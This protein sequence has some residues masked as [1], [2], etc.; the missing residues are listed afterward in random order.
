MN[1]SDFRKLA[2]SLPDTA[3][4]A[5]MGHPDFRVNGRIFAT[6]GPRDSWGMVKLSPELQRAYIA[7]DNDAFEPIKGAWGVQGCTKVILEFAGRDIVK[8]AMDDARK[9]ALAKALRKPRAKA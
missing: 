7:E 1:A 8:R 5:H 3:E 9:W 2:L 4:Q 6:L